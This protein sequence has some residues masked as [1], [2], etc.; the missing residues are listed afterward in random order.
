MR[1]LVTCGPTCE[2][3]DPVRFIT[4]R[5]TGKMGAEIIEE[6]C[7]RGAEVTVVSGPVNIAY[8]PWANVIPVRS[9]ADML[10]AVEDNLENSDVLI[11]AAAVADFTPASLS[12][13]KIK[14]GETKMT[15]LELKPTKDILLSIKHLKG[16]KFFIGFA[17]ETDNLLENAKDKMA[18]KSLDMIVANKVGVEGS[19][20]ASD[21][22]TGTI[23]LP[24]AAIP[25]ECM[26]K[27]ELAGTIL[28]LVR[29]KQ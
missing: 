26:A 28:D 4:N 27:A 12:P 15:G 2:D 3:I 13:S 5:S 20:F 7:L 23:L 25:F 10:K 22:N 14:K 29:D 8:A 16:K 17:A 19:G 18:R 21:T 11:M 24:G 6:A 1:I 9:A